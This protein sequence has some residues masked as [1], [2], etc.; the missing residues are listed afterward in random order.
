MAYLDYDERMLDSDGSDESPE[1][2]KLVVIIG[3]MKLW[4]NPSLLNIL[5]V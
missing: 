3:N 2:R 1:I 4:R 5:N